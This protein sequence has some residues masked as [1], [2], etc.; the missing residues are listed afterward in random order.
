MHPEGHFK[1]YGVMHAESHF[2][3]YFTYSVA[4]IFIDRRYWSICRNTDLTH[5]QP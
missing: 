4:V 2:K 3:Q 5:R 1:S